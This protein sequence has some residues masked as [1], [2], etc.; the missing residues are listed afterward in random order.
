MVFQIQAATYSDLNDL[1]D[2][3]VK[4]HS[5]DRLFEQLMPR[6]PY[7]AQ[8]KWYADA[9]RKT[10]EE[11]WVRYYKAV[12]SETKYASPPFHAKITSGPPQK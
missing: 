8:V 10:W 5:I 7:D 9:F 11:K 1:A 6:V 3:L 2:V 12:D 4:A